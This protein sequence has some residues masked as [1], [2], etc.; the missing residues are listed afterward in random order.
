MYILFMQKFE[1]YDSNGNAVAGDKSKEVCCIYIC[2]PILF[3]K[4]WLDV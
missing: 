1:A 4:G 2:L 3:N